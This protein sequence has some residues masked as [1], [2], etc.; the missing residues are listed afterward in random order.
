MWTSGDD[1][2]IDCPSLW[3]EVGD[4]YGSAMRM[5]HSRASSGLEVC[6]KP[7]ICAP[8]LGSS[9]EWS[10]SRQQCNSSDITVSMQN[11][12]YTVRVDAMRNEWQSMVF[13][14]ISII[15][16]VI[17]SK[18]SSL[19]PYFPMPRL[20]SQTRH[21]HSNRMEGTRVMPNS[22]QQRSSKMARPSLKSGRWK[23]G[24]LSAAPVHCSRAPVLH[25]SKVLVLHC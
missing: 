22:R 1:P 3:R 21:C 13:T 2:N 14:L 8:S 20:H 6:R 4:A 11:A 18:Y 9:H 23:M 24:R 5:I 15:L 17:L 16:Y 10:H 7:T 25:C 12:E 19:K